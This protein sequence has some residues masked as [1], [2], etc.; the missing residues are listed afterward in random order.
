MSAYQGFLE[1]YDGV[2]SEEGHRLGGYPFFTQTD[3]REW[4]SPFEQYRLLFQLDS[5]GAG[6]NDLGF[7]VLWGDAGV[8]NFFIHPDDL[9][10]RDF[11]RVA[12]NWDCC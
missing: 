10:Q 7:E 12:Y 2:F 6:D 5:D 11:S 9:K 8:G 4:G 3:F 1:S